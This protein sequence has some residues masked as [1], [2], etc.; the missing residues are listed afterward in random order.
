MT[1]SALALLA[2]TAPDQ[3]DRG[4]DPDA[5][6]GAGGSSR[7]GGA[8]GSVRAGA[9]G[10]DVG[11]AGEGPIGGSF[12]GDLG[13]TPIVSADEPP[14]PISGGTLTVTSDGKL[15]IAADPERDQVSIV[16]LASG[17]VTNVALRE[18]DEPGRVITDA[19]G[20]AHVALRGSGE[21]LTLALPSGAV[22]ARRAVC[23]NPRGLAFD[24]AAGAVLVACAEGHLVTMAAD[25]AGGVTRDV[26]VD[27]DLRDVAVSGDRVFVS[28]FRA[29]EL[30][31]LSRDGAVQERRRPQ[32]KPSAL[33]M[34]VGG[35]SGASSSGGAA[36]GP[37]T[38]ATA[39]PAVANVPPG[40]G[41]KSPAVAW[42][43][44]LRPD[45][46]PVMLH[47][48]G[49]DSEIPVM[50]GGYGGKCS[51]IVE[52]ALTDFAMTSAGLAR[53][54]FRV[55]MTGLA[56]D[57]AVS[58]GGT[59]VALASLGRPF[60]APSVTFTHGT[61]PDAGTAAGNCFPPEV[62]PPPDDNAPAPETTDELPEPKTYVQP[63]QD[64]QI[65]ALAF[66]P[67]GNLIAQGRRPARLYVLT[68][69]RAPIVLS[70]V[71]RE[72]TGHRLFHA[73]TVGGIA[74]AS[75]HPEG[76]DDGRTWKFTGIG[77][78]R[79][80][81]MRGKITQTAP[82]HW[83]GD[84]T[85]LGTLMTN[86]FQGRMSGPPVTAEH[87]A[88]LGKFLDSIPALAPERAPTDAAALR[89]RMVFA[90]A[91]CEACH[92]GPALT[93]NT[94]VDVGTGKPLQVPT[95][96]GISHRLPL[97][98]TGCAKTLV[99]RFDPSCGGGD[100]HGVTSSLGPAQIADLVAYL[101]TL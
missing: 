73:V 96:R 16:T 101:E 21:V 71:A 95:L 46:T 76:G 6:G 57:L 55:G 5:G 14:V 78:R 27:G 49:D 12:G 52:P 42:R 9:G 83:D 8:G 99:Q 20:R 11:G 68:Q 13:L 72:D 61:P 23:G 30:L 1:A 35:A 31:V 2:C 77:A 85:D 38:G 48:E 70:D 15:A 87:A 32:N 58:P 36:G 98:H 7:S 47:Q 75:C 41:P 51:G 62:T 53:T 18:H 43:M 82:F 86:V 90:A 65:V 60:D 4:P 67:R 69:N 80:Q 17:A 92:S 56:V 44:T 59:F 22:L 66:D 63:P 28:R 89:G 26:R 24:A 74:C 94:T 37:S 33:A 45:G 84:M 54:D 93:N 25:P 79:T 81:T 19:A 64:Q 40:F 88:V 91:G 34:G 39:P 3:L 10:A 29:A 100:R 50:G 97:M